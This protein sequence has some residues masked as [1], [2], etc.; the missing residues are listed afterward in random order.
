MW[1]PDASP[2]YCLSGTVVF[3]LILLRTSMLPVLKIRLEK[4]L[5]INVR[6]I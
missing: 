4:C 3:F 1:R 5:E 6:Q 2:I